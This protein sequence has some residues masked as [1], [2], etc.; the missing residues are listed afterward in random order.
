MNPG[1]ARIKDIARLAGVSI[2][3]IDRVLHNRGEVSEKTKEKVQKILRDTNYSPNVMAR[4]LKSRKSYHIVSLLPEATE[5]NS[6]WIKHPAGMDRAVA[7]LEPFPVELTKM[8]FD[9]Q[10]EADFQR[11]SDEVLELHPDGILL[12]PIF[13]SESVG[14]CRTLTERK[15]P[16]VFIDSFIRD[17]GFL[18][19]IGEDVYLSGRVAGELTD[20]VTEP[21]KNILIVN[22][23]RN[24]TNVH[25]LK[26]RTKGFLGYLDDSGIK[27]AGT[28]SISIKEP[29]EKEVSSDMES[30]LSRHPETGSVFITGSKSYLIANY[31]KRC[32]R[33]D[34]NIIG[35]DLLD[36]NVSLLKEGIIKFLI[37]QR[38]EEQAYLGIKKLMD[39]LSMNKI[40]EKYQYL[41]VDIIS[42]QNV[43]FFI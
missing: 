19:Y 12:A 21:G 7:E 37:G 15:I 1:K 38:P 42:S 18:S 36:E 29:T 27:S 11:K 10:S 3:T 32:G 41:P 5:I 13:K 24:L 17:T 4:A 31:L 30:V 8:N 20:L 28:L 14:F 26:N 33:K 43:D 35:Y 25:H 22:I 34:I 2:G 40:P 9:M 6:Y 39:Y 16:F 23:A